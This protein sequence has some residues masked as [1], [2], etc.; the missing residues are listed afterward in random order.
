MASCMT[1]HNGAAAPRECETCHDV[2]MASLVPASHQ[3]GWT[4]EH[5]RQAR[6]SDTSCLPCH[7]AAQC[8][9]CHDG[10]MLTELAGAGLRETPFTPAMEGDRGTALERVHGLNYRF[11][12]SLE[13]RAKTSD[14]L[15]CHELDAG[16]F[17]GQCH[18]PGGQLGVRPA[19]HGG[20]GWLTAG[21]NSGG[22]RHADLAR[23]DLE[24]CSVCH[25]GQ[26]QDPACLLCHMDR[27]PGKGNDPRTHARG[28][29]ADQGEGD[30]HTDRG[31]SC[32]S[33][34]VNQTRP[35]GFCSYCH[36]SRAREDEE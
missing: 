8:Q 31:A 18:N 23:R 24:N 3:P 7:R 28:F 25:E 35:N 29:A 17:C 20:A 36:A 34:H 19:W 6:L 13:A 10:A 15:S 2:P 16:D 14:C 5:G 22:G 32:F 26:G 27:T 21:V 12:H 1:C 4:R 11:V 9:E 33:C 30:F